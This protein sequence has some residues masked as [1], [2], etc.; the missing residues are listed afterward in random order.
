MATAYWSLDDLDRAKAAIHEGLRRFPSR[1]QAG[2]NSVVGWIATKRWV[3]G[4][5][6]SGVSIETI[7]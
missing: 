3:H 1:W 7:R 6:M 5:H 2:Y 4:E